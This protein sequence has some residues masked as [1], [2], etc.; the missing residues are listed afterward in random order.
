MFLKLS[1]LVMLSEHEAIASE[2]VYAYV[3]MRVRL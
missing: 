3:C 2:H 1:K